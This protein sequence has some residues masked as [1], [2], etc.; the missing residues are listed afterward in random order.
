MIRSAVTVSLVPGRYT[1]GIVAMAVPFGATV[2]IGNGPGAGI[3]D[4]G[5]ATEV[6]QSGAVKYRAS[7]QYASPLRQSSTAR[8]R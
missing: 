5:F 4:G 3:P 7:Y 8:S 2:P 6:H 1:N